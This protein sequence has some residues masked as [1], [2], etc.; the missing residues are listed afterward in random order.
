MHQFGGSHLQTGGKG[1]KKR[2][3]RSRHDGVLL[4]RKTE[5]GGMLFT[6]GTVMNTGSRRLVWNL[7]V[8]FLSHFVVLQSETRSN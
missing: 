4:H 6:A 8:F 1:G 5:T 7:F 3:G 2:R